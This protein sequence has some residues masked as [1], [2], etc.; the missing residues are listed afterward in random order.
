MNAV[1]QRSTRR[2]GS[3]FSRSW[4][5]ARTCA[6]AA[7]R[8]CVSTSRRI[9]ALTGNSQLR[10]RPE[11]GQ[12]R[13]KCRDC[14]DLRYVGWPAFPPVN[15]QLSTINHQLPGGWPAFPSNPLTH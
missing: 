13:R 4:P 7:L 14:S 6:F 5:S 9:Q 1:P 3:T 15:P 11:R 8:L 12:L 2:N 10:P